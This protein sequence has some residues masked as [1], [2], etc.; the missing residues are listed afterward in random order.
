MIDCLATDMKQITTSIRQILN[1]LLAVSGL[2]IDEQ[3]TETNDL[4]RNKKSTQN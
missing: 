4:K 3:E 2:T 1:E